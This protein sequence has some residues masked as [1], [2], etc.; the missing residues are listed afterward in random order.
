MNES[1]ERM[2]GIKPTRESPPDLSANRKS[3]AQY[4]TLP[5][6]RLPGTERTFSPD[7]AVNHVISHAIVA[8]AA[9]GSHRAVQL[10]SS[11]KGYTLT[12]PWQNYYLGWESTSLYSTKG[13]PM[14]L[15]LGVA[16]L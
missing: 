16:S 9:I 13:S 15:R 8:R 11:G 1:S 2:T 6:G 3:S 4:L 7:G 5:I 14:P 12:V 10:L